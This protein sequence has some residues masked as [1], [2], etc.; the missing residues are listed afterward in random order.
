MARSYA[1]I[2]AL[3]AMLVVFVRAIKN[4][5]GLEQTLVVAAAWMALFGAIGF[6]LATIARN[7]VDHS[8]QQAVETELAALAPSNQQEQTETSPNSPSPG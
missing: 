8:V 2:M 6:I 3:V 1:A 5:A 4:H 7:A